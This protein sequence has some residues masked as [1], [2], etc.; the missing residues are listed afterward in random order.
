MNW[1]AAAQS[2]APE[3]VLRRA[4]QNIRANDM[5]VSKRCKN[6]ANVLNHGLGTRDICSI[7]PDVMQCIAKLV[8]VLDR[9]RRFLP[10]RLFDIF[11][12]I[13]GMRA[14]LLIDI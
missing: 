6:K 12:F 9:D 4:C 3:T 14:L 2:R 5:S 11:V 8:D 13:L 1:P 10:C 7:T